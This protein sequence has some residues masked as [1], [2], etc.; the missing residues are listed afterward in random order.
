MAIFVAPIDWISSTCGGRKYPNKEPNM[1][2]R[3]TNTL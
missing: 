3:N 2:G 1:H